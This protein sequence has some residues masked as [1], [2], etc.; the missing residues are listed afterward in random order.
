MSEKK[1]S[2]EQ[3]TKEPQP[4]VEQSNEKPPKEDQFSEEQNSEEVAKWKAEFET[5]ADVDGLI[6][7]DDLERCLQRQNK[8]PTQRD[9]Q[10][11]L[12]SIDKNG[13]EKIGW[14]EFVK[15]QQEA[16]KMTFYSSDIQLDLE[17]ALEAFDD[18]ND[19]TISKDE[20]KKILVDYDDET[21][22]EVIKEA[23]TNSDGQLS[24][25]AFYRHG[26]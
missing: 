6:T 14:E 22:D 13:D 12:S 21:L 18:N 1:T 23:D 2:A 8:N 5:L 9:M 15:F 17:K 26:C 24:I 20:L 11:L 25:K 10:A 7:S 19:G 3:S 4:S 16:S